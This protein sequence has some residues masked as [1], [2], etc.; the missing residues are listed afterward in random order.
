M[1]VVCPGSGA[2]LQL[3]ACPCLCRPQW[4]V[5]TWAVRTGTCDIGDSAQWAYSG[6]TVTPGYNHTNTQVPTEVNPNIYNLFSL[7]KPRPSPP[8]PVSVTVSV[9][10]SAVTMVIL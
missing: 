9:E 3:V 2:T 5:V 7:V 1:A 10:F 6:H 8:F 4:S